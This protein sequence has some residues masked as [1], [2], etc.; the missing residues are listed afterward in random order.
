MILEYD[1]VGGRVARVITPA[2]EDALADDDL[3]VLF[4]V[5]HGADQAE[6]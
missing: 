2:M 5:L 3:V 4:F 1:R 6:A